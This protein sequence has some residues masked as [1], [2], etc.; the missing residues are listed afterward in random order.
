M[1]PLWLSQKI[2]LVDWGDFT[3]SEHITCLPKLA[4]SQPNPNTASQIFFGTFPN[5]FRNHPAGSCTHST[6]TQFISWYQYTKAESCILQVFQWIYTLLPRTKRQVP[7]ICRWCTPGPFRVSCPPVSIK[8]QTYSSVI[9]TFLLGSTHDH[10]RGPPRPSWKLY[11]ICWG[12][13]ATLPGRLIVYDG[14]LC[15]I[16]VSYYESSNFSQ[17]MD[18][19]CHWVEAANLFKLNLLCTHVIRSWCNTRWNSS[20]R[21]KD[22]FWWRDVMCTYSLKVDILLGSSA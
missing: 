13:A 3:T 10:A 17:V 1:H 14:S 8:N 2:V 5:L 6:L 18:I 11:N 15:Q 12:F 21:M 19:S 9:L 22:S 16:L 20:S 7:T 4:V